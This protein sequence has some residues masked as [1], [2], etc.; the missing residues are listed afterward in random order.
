[1]NI[2]KKP[3]SC[4]ASRLFPRNY[5]VS[6]RQK[7]LVLFQKRERI[8][9]FC[10]NQFRPTASM[11]LADFIMKKPPKRTGQPEGFV[12]FFFSAEQTIIP[13]EACLLPPAFLPL[14]PLNPLAPL[15]QG[16]T[17]Q[18]QCFQVSLALFTRSDP[19]ISTPAQVIFAKIGWSDRSQ[20]TDAYGVPGYA[21]S[22]RAVVRKGH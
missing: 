21:A 15:I 11:L 22:I 12:C 10:K 8:C 5:P 19:Y 20:F 9:L 1:L 6:F 13:A 3:L 17:R 2:P 16:E 7:V 14:E 4:S 18:C